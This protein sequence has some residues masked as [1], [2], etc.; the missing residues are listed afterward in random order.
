MRAKRDACAEWDASVKRAGKWTKD[1][2]RKAKELIASLTG[3][4]SDTAGR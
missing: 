4:H 2:D 3:E 1:D